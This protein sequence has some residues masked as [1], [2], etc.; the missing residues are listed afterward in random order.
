MPVNNMQNS[1]RTQQQQ[2][3]WRNM[4]RWSKFKLSL[5]PSI[6]CGLNLMIEFF[7]HSLNIGSSKMICPSGKMI[8]P[9]FNLER[10]LDSETECQWT[11]ESSDIFGIENFQSSDQ[12]PCFAK[13]DNFEFCQLN[14]LNMGNHLPAW[15]QFAWRSKLLDSSVGEQFCSELFREDFQCSEIN[16]SSSFGLVNFTCFSAQLS[17]SLQNPSEIC[18]RNEEFQFS[19]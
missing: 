9:F 8:I 1:W 19:V 12:M 5:V 11:I 4:A 13:F 7:W 14:K 6:C 10:I 17:I 15:L 3:S 2:Q 18:E 16:S